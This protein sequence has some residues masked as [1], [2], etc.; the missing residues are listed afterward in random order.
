MGLNAAK[1]LVGTAEQSSTT[2][3]I[4]TGDV[5]TT[6]PTTFSAAETA[7]NAMTG[8]GYISEDG[9]EMGNDMSVTEIK[10]WNKATVRKVLD[11]WDNTLAFSIIQADYEGWCQAIGEEYVTQTAA[12]TTHGEQLHIQLGAHMA[13]NK[14][15]GFAV[16]DGDARVI[17]LCPN[18]QVSTLD[19]ITF[20][21]SEAVALPVTVTA[22]DDGQGTG[23]TIHIY[24]DDG[25][26]TS[27]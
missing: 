23:D 19:S 10:E 3:A 17:V 18:G 12:T 24:Y 22:Y 13:P 21:A 14:S 16:K 8:S 26:T 1:V 4:R 15:W 2:G 6:I 5:L 7:L 9:V 25:E 20:A 11:S 27:G